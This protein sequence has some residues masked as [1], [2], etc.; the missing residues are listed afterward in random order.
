MASSSQGFGD[1]SNTMLFLVLGSIVCQTQH[2]G[3]AS[4]VNAITEILHKPI[5]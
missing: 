5:G 2:T 3:F 4:P 1:K